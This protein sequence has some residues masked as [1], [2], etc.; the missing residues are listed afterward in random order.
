MPQNS[1]PNPRPPGRVTPHHLHRRCSCADFV[2]L[3]VRIRPTSTRAH[4]GGGISLGDRGG[5]R[6]ALAE[7]RHIAD[8]QLAALQGRSASSSPRSMFSSAFR[9]NS[10]N[11]GPRYR[12][13]IEPV[14]SATSSRMSIRSSS[15][16]ALTSAALRSGHLTRYMGIRAIPGDA[17]TWCNRWRTTRERATCHRLGVPS[18][19]RLDVPAVVSGVR[20]VGSAREGAI[21]LHPGQLLLE[22][23]ACRFR[24]ACTEAKVVRP[25]TDR[26]ARVARELGRR[27][28]QHRRIGDGLGRRR[29]NVAEPHVDLHGNARPA[30]HCLDDAAVGCCQHRLPIRMIIGHAGPRSSVTAPVRAELNQIEGEFR[31]QRP[32]M[33]GVEGGA[34]LH[35]PCS[36]HGEAQ[37]CLRHSGRNRKSDFRLRWPARRRSDHADP[38]ATPK[39][40]DLVRD[41][42]RLAFRQ[43]GTTEPYTAGKDLPV[44]ADQ[45][46][47]RLGDGGRLDLAARLG[48]PLKVRPAQQARLHHPFIVEKREFHFVHLERSV[49]LVDDRELMEEKPILGAGVR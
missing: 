19:P 45:I 4:L 23:S 31:G 30:E 34:A 48:E 25:A 36:T 42:K 14:G 26:L 33:M 28:L 2:R 20:V 24:N 10:R 49:A 11:T 18:E 16:A 9:W 13:H 1:A 38:Y 15:L 39:S 43:T 41:E 35:H 47:R 40:E 5:Q 21:A 7:R 6:I 12:V 27:E 17:L 37:V 46:D 44:A 8:L 3:C 32:A 29:D 22:S